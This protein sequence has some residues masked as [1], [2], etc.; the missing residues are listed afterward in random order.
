[1]S[2]ASAGDITAYFDTA[3]A[4][5]KELGSSINEM[6]GATAD[7]SRMGKSLPDSKELAEVAILYKNVGDN[8]DV[9]EATSSLV[10]TLQGFQMDAKEAIK[11]VDAFNEVA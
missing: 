1:V 11:I 5:A 4:S 6:I 7:W 9:E 8:I 2:D 3:A 10:S